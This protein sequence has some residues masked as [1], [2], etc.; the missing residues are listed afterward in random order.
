M[1]FY[2]SS[3]TRKGKGLLG[4]AM[5]PIYEDVNQSRSIVW[6]LAHIF[7]TLFFRNWPYLYYIYITI[8]FSVKPISFSEYAS[9]SSGSLCTLDKF[10]IHIY[11]WKEKLGQLSSRE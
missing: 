2:E 1:E 9:K 3:F 5:K 10:K 6:S 7:W 8:K 4:R 11:K